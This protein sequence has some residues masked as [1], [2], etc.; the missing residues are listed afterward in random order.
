MPDY[1]Y[2]YGFKIRSYENVSRRNE[3]P[4]INAALGT[5]QA[6]F[7]SYASTLPLPPTELFEKQDYILWFYLITSNIA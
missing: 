7:C 5:I 3:N 4:T 6:F 1:Y 2:Y